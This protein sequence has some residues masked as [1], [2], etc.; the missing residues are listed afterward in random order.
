MFAAKEMQAASSQ[1]NNKAFPSSGEKAIYANIATYFRN[2]LNFTVKI[3]PNHKETVF[4]RRV[5]YKI[6]LAQTLIY[7]NKK[8]QQL[9]SFFICIY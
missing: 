2:S 1:T 8:R 7:T 3:H 6:H 9:L 5:P 4:F